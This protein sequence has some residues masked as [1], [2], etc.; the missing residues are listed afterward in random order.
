MNR[1]LPVVLVAALAVGGCSSPDPGEP[2][3]AVPGGAAA[4]AVPG[5]AAALPG[6]VPDGLALR[7]PPASAPTAPKFTATLTDGSSL[8]AARLWADRPVVLVFFTS[9][10]TACADRQ[11]ALSD[12]ARTYRDRVVFVGVASEDKPEALADFLRVHRVD[13]PVAT[14]PEMAIWQSYA[15]REPP[16]IALISKGGR[17]LRGWPGGVDAAALD[18]ALRTQILAP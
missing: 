4:T 15:M 14:D 13:Y 16:G 18:E 17:L 12:L 3:T 1:W 9:W 11:D 2:A 10:C 8:E 7:E 6:P 5:G